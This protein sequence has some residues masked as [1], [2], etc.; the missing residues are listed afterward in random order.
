MGAKIIMLKLHYPRLDLAKVLAKKPKMLLL[1]YEKL[2]QQAQQ[3]RH[4]LSR[5]KD[6]ERLLGLVPE[7]LDPKECISILITVTKW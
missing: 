1:S 5:A 3:V 6:L 2:D 4:L 7:L